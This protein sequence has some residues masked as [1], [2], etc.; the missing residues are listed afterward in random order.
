MKNIKTSRFIS[1]KVVLEH[2]SLSPTPTSTPT[3]PPPPR[4]KIPAEFYGPVK[5]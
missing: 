1:N 4:K 3:P 2:N 5:Y